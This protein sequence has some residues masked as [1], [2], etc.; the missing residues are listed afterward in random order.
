MNPDLYRVLS[1]RRI[2]SLLCQQ[3]VTDLIE[4]GRKQCGYRLKT[5]CISGTFNILQFVPLREFVMFYIQTPATNKLHFIKCFM[6]M[7]HFI[8]QGEGGG[9]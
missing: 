3:A 1:D 4:P 9:V 7:F 6:L 2:L 8:K 5:Y